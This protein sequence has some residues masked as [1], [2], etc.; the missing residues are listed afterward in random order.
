MSADLLYRSLPC[1]L[2][3]EFLIELRLAPASSSDPPVSGPQ[4]RGRVC[5]HVQHLCV[6]SP[7]FVCNHAQHL[8][9]T[10]PSICV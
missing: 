4:G 6:T 1:S 3:T 7:A 9:V 10:M 2:L 5:N 8:C